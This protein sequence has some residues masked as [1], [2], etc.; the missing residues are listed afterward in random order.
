MSSGIS[1]RHGPHQVAQKLTT[2][3]LPKKSASLNDAP[4]AS[5]SGASATSGG[6]SVSAGGAAAT[7]GAGVETGALAFTGSGV[8][9]VTT[10]AEIITRLTT[11][12]IRRS[13]VQ[14]VSR[15][16]SFVLIDIFYS[17]LL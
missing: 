12:L 4:F 14:T 15:E 5:F 16:R 13:R 8:V 11:T 6:K 10:V 9:A 17:L 2:A 1:R 7:A 3:T